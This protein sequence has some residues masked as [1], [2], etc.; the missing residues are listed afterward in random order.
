VA[1]RQV[2]FDFGKNFRRLHIAFGAHDLA[3]SPE[4]LDAIIAGAPDGQKITQDYVREII[5]AKHREMV[6][7]HEAEA[8]K[9]KEA[10]EKAQKAE[11]AAR[12]KEREAT[13]EAEKEKAAKASEKAAKKTAEAQKAARQVRT[14]PK[15]RDVVIEKDDDQSLLSISLD[16]HIGPLEAIKLAKETKEKL[17][18]YAEQITE[19]TRRALLEESIKAANTWRENNRVRLIGYA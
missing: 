18:K 1:Q 8:E 9:R 17:E 13:D 16:L 12:K 15:K 4:R 5:A 11:E 10:L 7:A 3:R 19:N 14:L 2:S 6:A